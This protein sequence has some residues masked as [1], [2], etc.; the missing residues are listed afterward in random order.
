MLCGTLFGCGGG[1]G[2]NPM[3]STPVAQRRLLTSGT[4]QL[5]DPATAFASTGGLLSSDFAVVPFNVGTAG[6]L[7]AS[8]NWTFASNDIDIA[9]VQGNCTLEQA[10]ADNCGTELVTGVTVTKPETVRTSVS[11]GPH[12]LV[13]LNLG[14]GSESGT[15]EIFLTN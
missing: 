15:F 12:T 8:V 6:T 2:S 9:I 13:L 3:A 10:V 11:T 4:F 1:G 5:T 14:P 7:D